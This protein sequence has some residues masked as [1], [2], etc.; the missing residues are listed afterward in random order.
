[1]RTPRFQPVPP[2]ADGPWPHCLTVHWTREALQ[3]TPGLCSHLCPTEHSH[4]TSPV[5]DPNMVLLL[6]SLPVSKLEAAK[7]LFPELSQPALGDIL[8]HL[9]ALTELGGSRPSTATFA[10]AAGPSAVPGPPGAILLRSSAKPLLSLG[11]RSILLQ[12]L[13]QNRVLHSRSG[14]GQKAHRLSRGFPLATG[15]GFCP[16][17]RGIRG[18]GRHRAPALLDGSAPG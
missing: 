15:G 7:P 6:Q 5:A 11:S 3:Q 16:A 17:L 14:P 18:V 8:S 4:C 9:S 12:G 1:M 10:L 13:G 2:P